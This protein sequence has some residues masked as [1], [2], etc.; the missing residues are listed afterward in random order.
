MPLVSPR[1]FD[2]WAASLATRGVMKVLSGGALLGGGG[3]L[4]AFA[5]G[6]P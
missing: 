6:V 3:G 4:G 1:R 5:A 2:P